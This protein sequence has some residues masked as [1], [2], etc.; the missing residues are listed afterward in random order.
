MWLD[1]ITS[2]SYKFAFVL[3]VFQL[4]FLLQVVENNTST[5]YVLT[6]KTIIP[7]GQI[8]RRGEVKNDVCQLYQVTQLGG[9]THSYIT[10]NLILLIEVSDV[11]DD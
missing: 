6:E 2:F 11:Q 1:S 3:Q 9:I 7:M 5:E 10:T 8:L 4:S